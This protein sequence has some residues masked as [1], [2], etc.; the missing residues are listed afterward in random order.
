MIKI[1]FC[2]R[3]KETSEQTKARVDGYKKNRENR[4]AADPEYQKGEADRKKADRSKARDPRKVAAKTSNAESHRQK[5]AEDKS[6][7]TNEAEAE[8]KRKSRGTESG[9]KRLAIS[10]NQSDINTKDLPI[11]VNGYRL[12]KLR[13]CGHCK[14]KLYKNEPDSFCCGNGQIDI[15]V[16][17]IP[18]RL[19]KLLKENKKFKQHI[20][21]YNNALALTSIGF[22]GEERMPGFNPVLKIHGKCYHRSFKIQTMF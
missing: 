13:E 20:R 15:T 12:K 11:S 9:E 17:K 3:N 7:D 6:A 22:D 4:K 1:I 21:K 10:Q 14:A 8:R 19:Y 18:N 5:R 2:Y 16:P